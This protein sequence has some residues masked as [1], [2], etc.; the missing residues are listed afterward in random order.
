MSYIAG[1]GLQEQSSCEVTSA[2]TVI[3][4]VVVVNTQSNPI[5]SESH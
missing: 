2:D 3:Q 4:R 1:A 5:K